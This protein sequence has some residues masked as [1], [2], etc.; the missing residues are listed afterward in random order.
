MD[1]KGVSNRFL[2]ETCSH[3]FLL[4]VPNCLIQ[5]FQFSVMTHLHSTVSPRKIYRVIRLHVGVK[6]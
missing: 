2:E 1:V 6:Q 3:T 5:C 4:F